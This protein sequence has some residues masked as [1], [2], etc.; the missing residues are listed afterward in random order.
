M[1]NILV[2]D[3]EPDTLKLIT[4]ML[5][6]AG[7]QVWPV[8]RGKDAL[9]QAT[10]QRPDIIVLDVMLPDLDGFS[11]AQKL[12]TQFEN[13]PPIIFFTSMNSPEDQIT[14]RTLGDGYL[15][16]PV[17]LTLLLET[18]QKLLTGDKPSA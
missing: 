16:K 10:K 18:V 5:A 9:L 3:D 6:R 8:E 14:G 15:V 2:V 4:M 13:P 17:R 7:Y 11:V 1:V 12:H